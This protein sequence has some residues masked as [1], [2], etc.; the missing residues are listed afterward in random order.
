MWTWLDSFVFNCDVEILKIRV[1]GGLLMDY[2][3]DFTQYTFEI[4][5]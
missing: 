2:G 1:E 5:L 3:Y 4:F